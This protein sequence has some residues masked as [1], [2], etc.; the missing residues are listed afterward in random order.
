MKKSCS[1]LLL[2]LFIFI[3][4]I[5][6]IYLLA[7]IIIPG[8]VEPLFGSPNP[9]LTPIQR[10]HYS[11]QLY[12]NKDELLNPDNSL[13][14][15][16]L[17]FQIQP[18]ESVQSITQRL[19]AERLIKNSDLFEDLLVYSGLDILMQTGKFKLAPSMSPV[20]IAVSLA[21]PANG[22]ITFSILPGWRLEEIAASLPS[23]G[24]NIR[25][26]DFLRIARNPGENGIM[27]PI[28]RGT[29]LEGLLFAG[30]YEI[31]RDAN[32]EDLINTILASNQ[33]L[34]SLDI[35]NSLEQQGLSVYDGI[36]LASIVQRESVRE[37]EMT[38][39][40]SVFLNRLKL[41]MKLDSDPTVQYSLGYDVGKN[42]WWKNPLFLGDLKNDS[43]YNTYI[44]AGLPP[45]PINSPSLEAIKAV[46]FPKNTNF[47]FFQANCDGKGFHNFAAT[48]EEHLNNSCP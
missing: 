29:S 42:T 20:E 25:P 12:L 11:V 13:G 22:D 30:L 32:S 7:T 26:E 27:T 35:K 48:F 41:G 39:I 8:K 2:F 1:G 17:A 5:I 44:H 36:I 37:D 38:T 34:I 45:T 14:I 15:P 28:S 24:L 16:P 6:G 23:S 4:F 9:A 21:N 46:A 18:G 43:L 10:I 40:A 33:E 31:K 3:L 47:L 19:A